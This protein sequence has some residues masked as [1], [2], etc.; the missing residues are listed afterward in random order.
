MLTKPLEC[1]SCKFYKIGSGFIGDTV[2][3]R[4]ITII[5]YLTS[6]DFIQLDRQFPDNCSFGRETRRFITDSLELDNEEEQDKLI[7]YSTLIRCYL[8][9]VRNYGRGNR[10]V[11]MQ[12][13]A[14]NRLLDEIKTCKSLHD[15][16]RYSIA[17]FC[18]DFIEG[19]ETPS[20]KSII[21]TVL[22]KAL[23]LYRLHD[24]KVGVYMGNKCLEY[25]LPNVR[26]GDKVFS[27][28]YIFT[29]E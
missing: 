9:S 22:R 5:R 1:N 15:K 12:R 19:I 2:P 8:G 6:K 21:A 25:V 18:F 27:G 20:Y 17:M 24:I 4:P 16:N 23:R 7:G 29:G 13:E 28:H 14:N 11:D 10:L 26:G 3:Q